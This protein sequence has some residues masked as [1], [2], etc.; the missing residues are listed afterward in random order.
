M[1]N[2]KQVLEKNGKFEYVRKGRKKVI[3]KGV[4]LAIPDEDKLAIG[5]SLCHSVE[6]KFDPNFGVMVARDRALDWW[7]K[8][9]CFKSKPKN[10]IEVYQQ[11]CQILATLNQPKKKKIPQSIIKQLA[12][13]AYRMS[14]YYKDKKLPEWIEL[15]MAEAAGA[16]S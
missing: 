5:W 7:D 8:K 16:K 1:E 15:L 12:H 11:A 10:E 4:L 2:I 9:V 13:F 3:K 6:E 14:R